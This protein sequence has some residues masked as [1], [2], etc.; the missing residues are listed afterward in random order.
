MLT[1]K[2]SSIHENSTE[3]T[4]TSIE[5][6]CHMIYMIFETIIYIIVFLLIIILVIYLGVIIILTCK[7]YLRKRSARKYDYS[8]DES[9]MEIIII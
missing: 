7:S 4:P 6:V 1:S 8:S 9:E 5:I 3:E 2:L